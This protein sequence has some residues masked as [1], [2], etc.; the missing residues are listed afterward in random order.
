MIT[1]KQAGKQAREPASS[2]IDSLQS[3]HIAISGNI[4]LD[5]AA[6]PT[7]ILGQA[8]EA[9]AT[10]RATGPLAAASPSLNLV[11]GFASR[12]IQIAANCSD[13]IALFGLLAAELIAIVDQAHVAS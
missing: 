12:C 8:G 5:G 4:S 6:H 13:S 1:S 3:C 10:P 11:D 7:M 9:T 2:L